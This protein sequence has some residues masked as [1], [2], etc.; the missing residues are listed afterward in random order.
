MI[1]NQSEIKT[2]ISLSLCVFS[3]YLASCGNPVTPSGGPK[4]TTAPKINRIIIDSNKTQTIIQLD[5]NENITVKGQLTI[6]PLAPSSN[7][8]KRNSILIQVPKTTKTVYLTNKIVDLNESN[9]YFGKNISL[10]TDTGIIQ[11]INMTKNTKLSVFI[12][13]DSFILV[14]NNINKYYKFENLNQSESYLTIINKDDNNYSIDKNEEF[15]HIKLNSKFFNTNDTIKI[16]HLIPQLLL[17]QEKKEIQP[18]IILKTKTIRTYTSNQKPLN[19]LYQNDSCIEYDSQTN[20]QLKQ[21]KIYTLIDQKDTLYLKERN[22]TNDSLIKYNSPIL[23]SKAN[24]PVNGK[25]QSLGK[26]RINNSSTT[27]SNYYLY[28]KNSE[29]QFLLHIKYS[30]SVYLP[31]GTYQCMVSLIP[32][33]QLQSDSK[34]DI[35]L[36]QFQN[37]I[38]I[39]SKLENNL[40]LPNKEL[41][42]IGITY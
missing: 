32:F 30:D 9:P 29:Y 41:F 2:I 10:T 38:I 25:T 22:S 1:N 27:I 11:L 39:N 34:E 28:L 16:N 36:Y 7:T 13:S 42:N 6:S 21:G 20:Y 37:D 33:E 15:L 40:I 4:D 12:K 17:Y 31:I 18:G 14:P 35:L 3:F 8:V 23:F 26:L 24:K 5:F 19:L